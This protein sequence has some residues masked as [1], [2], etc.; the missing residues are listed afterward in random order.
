MGNWSISIAVVAV[1]VLLI[2]YMSQQKLKNKMLCTFIRPNRQKIE[3]WVPLQSK[4]V[5]FDRGRYGIGH[6][7]CDPMCITMLWYDRGFNK[8]FPMLIPT[9]EFKWDTPN[10]LNPATFESTWHSPEARQAAWEEHQ[11]TAFARA[12]AAQAGKKGLFGGMG[13]WLLPVIA[14]ILIAAVL[15]IVYKGL[16]GL[17]RRLFDLEQ[18]IKI[19]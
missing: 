16:G 8:L 7:E 19:K 13:S 3:K 11:H 5:V 9:L 2:F 17:D 12:A 18:L 1:F 15:F 6:Y 10:P 4:Y 14:I